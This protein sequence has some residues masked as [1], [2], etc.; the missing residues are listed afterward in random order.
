MIFLIKRLLTVILVGIYVFSFNVLANDSSIIESLEPYGEFYIYGEENEKVAKVLG[1]SQDSL[2]DYCN[3]NGVEYLA[4]NRDNTKQIKVTQEIT[5][6]SNSVIN[7]N[8]LS[9]GSITALIPDITGVEGAKGEVITKDGQKFVL[10]Q[11]KTSDSGGEYVLTQYFTVAER[12][13]IVLSFYTKSKE[14]REY[15]EKTFDSFSS[16]LFSKDTND[17]TFEISIVILV[18]C[19]LFA[20]ATVVIGFTIIKDIRQE[21]NAKEN[22]EQTENTEENEN[23][24]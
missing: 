2:V 4:V 5:D 3:E 14:D 19:G 22:I 20:I 18:A 8:A 9:D 15:I 17:K 13:S 7:L 1:M 10:T 23:N 24:D 21:K 12:R 11:F 16:H 6:F